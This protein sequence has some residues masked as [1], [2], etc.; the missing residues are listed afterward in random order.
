MIKKD[1]LRNADPSLCAKH[2][3]KIARLQG[4]K[5]GGHQRRV[6]VNLGTEGFKSH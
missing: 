1:R 5:A 4:I 2:V 3:Y 6:H